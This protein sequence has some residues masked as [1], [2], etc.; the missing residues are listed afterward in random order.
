MLTSSKTSHP[1]AA[2]ATRRVRLS[3]PDGR[4]SGFRAQMTTTATTGKRNPT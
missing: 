3:I 4:E 2:N 1:R